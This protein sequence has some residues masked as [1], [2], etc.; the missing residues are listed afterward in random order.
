MRKRT[1]H[2]G[3]NL[4]SVRCF[5]YGQTNS[6]HF[7]TQDYQGP[8][9]HSAL[10]QQG[11]SREEFLK[12]HFGAS[13]FSRLETYLDGKTDKEKS[14]FLSEICARKKARSKRGGTAFFDDVRNGLL[15]ESDGFSMNTLIAQ[16]ASVLE[17][18]KASVFAGQLSG[19]I[20]I[21][22]EA[23]HLPT[24]STEASQIQHVVEQLEEQ[25]AVNSKSGGA[26]NAVILSKLLL[27]SLLR[28]KTPAALFSH[29]NTSFSEEQA[30]WVENCFAG[31]QT[32]LNV[33]LSQL[34]S[35]EEFL[36][37]CLTL[38]QSDRLVHSPSYLSKSLNDYYEL[39][40]NEINKV[41]H[42]LDPT[43]VVAMLKNN[44]T[45]LE[46]KESAL[47]FL[48][49]SAYEMTAFALTGMKQVK[50][51]LLSAYSSKGLIEPGVDDLCGK[52]RS[53]IQWY[54]KLI[55]WNLV[56]LSSDVSPDIAKDMPTY[57]GFF[58]PENNDSFNLHLKMPKSSINDQIVQAEAN[59]RKSVSNVSDHNMT[60]IFPESFYRTN[61]AT[62]PADACKG[63]PY[64][65]LS[66]ESRANPND[67]EMYI[68]D[69]FSRCL[70]RIDSICVLQQG[71]LSLFEYP[72]KIPLFAG[73]KP[74]EMYD[75][76]RNTAV[77]YKS[78]LQSVLPS[79]RLIIDET[80]GSCLKSKKILTLEFQNF[81]NQIYLVT[82][83]YLHDV[84]MLISH[85]PTDKIGLD[86]YKFLHSSAVMTHKNNVGY[87]NEVASY[88][89]SAWDTRYIQC[90]RQ[91][92]QNLDCI[93]ITTEPW[94]NTAFNAD[95][96]MKTTLDLNED[97]L[98]RF[99]R[100]IAVQQQD[101]LK[102]KQELS[103]LLNS[104]HPHT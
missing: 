48:H 15:H 89:F 40:C 66:D 76:I 97:N 18:V 51:Y 85:L 53:S 101:L 50:D 11:I 65:R 96:Q 5:L 24:I 9:P 14:D 3:L 42:I 1:V 102:L 104:E 29:Q 60:V 94:Q 72:C 45:Y 38:S 61:L 49:S 84:E 12:C 58:C 36:A 37:Q 41:R 95:S 10:H 28:E 64:P 71:T 88:W 68:I 73:V 75:K 99:A 87:Y 26:N 92:N 16:N 54:R 6:E 62:N 77:K 57:A 69:A 7:D 86:E 67:P 103:S 74:Q 91:L 83:E 70:K 4:D 8:C 21:V 34:G 82:E 90:L 20:R 22:L 100:E 39:K 25:A 80:L 2:V 19:Y 27:S 81:L 56:L 63:N 32:N 33:L 17:A 55:Y 59:F 93:Q 13:F 52:Y 46:E 98:L 79:P 31:V 44:D 78:F 30:Y 43:D 23:E 35:Q 47:I